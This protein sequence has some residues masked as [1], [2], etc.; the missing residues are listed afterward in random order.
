[1]CDDNYITFLYIQTIDGALLACL[2]LSSSAQLTDTHAG[3]DF[4]MACYVGE[5]VRLVQQV[6]MLSRARDLRL[7]IE[8]QLHQQNDLTFFGL[9]LL[10]YRVIKQIL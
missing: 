7:R 10:H 1:M 4:V 9:N 8:V 6:E 3:K 2:S 5:T